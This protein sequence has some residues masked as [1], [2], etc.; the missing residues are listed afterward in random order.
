MGF[1]INEWSPETCD[2]VGKQNKTKFTSQHQY[3]SEK[4]FEE[5]ILQIKQSFAVWIG[6]IRPIHTRN[7]LMDELTKQID[8]FIH[9]L[10]EC[11]VPYGSVHT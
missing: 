11:T 5:R 6:T 9:E 3:E 8:K 2:K 10:N 4:N 7:E 1:E